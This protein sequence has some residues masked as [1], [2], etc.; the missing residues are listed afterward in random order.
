MASF[1]LFITYCKLRNEILT[2]LDIQNAYL[3][4][5]VTK[6]IYMKQPAGFIDPAHSSAES[7]LI[8]ASDAMREAVWLSNVGKSMGIHNLINMY[9]DNKAAVDI[10]NAKGLT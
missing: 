4:A 7:E 5:K 3:H 1:H 2:H 6:D 10:A 9:I 8:A